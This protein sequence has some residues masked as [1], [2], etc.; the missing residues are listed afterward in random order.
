MNSHNPVQGAEAFGVYL[1]YQASTPLDR[2]VFEAMEPYLTGG[3]GNPHAVDHGYGWQADAAVSL[4]R[5]KIADLIG[6]DSDEIIF[7]SGA[8]E[9]NNLALLGAAR[10]SPRHRRRVLV[11]AIEHKCILAAARALDEEGF[12]VTILPV[13]SEGIIDVDSLREEIDGATAVVSVMS[14]NNEIGSLQPIATVAALSH[15]AGAL[16]HTDAAQALAVAG[17]DVNQSGADLM[18]LSAHKAYGPKGIGVL[19]VRREMRSRIRPVLFGG[20]QEDG[21]RPGT[22]PTSLCVGFGR[23]AEILQQERSNE[24]ARISALRDRLLET[25]RCRAPDLVLNGPAT[26]RHA[27]NLN[28]RFPGVAADLLLAAA[29]PRIAAAT[30][31]ACTSGTPEPS[32]VLTAMGIS[33]TAAGESIRLSIG[34]FTSKP[35]IDEAVDALA[36][37]LEEVRQGPEL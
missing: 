11:S 6:A 20:G 8:T 37:A 16:F 25:L 9:A 4:A 1:D 35:D 23:A 17:V 5:S 24:V 30:G 15:A 28:L 32:H 26:D 12:E 7:T 13:S 36:Q 3:I 27:G 31:S 22:L 21:L 10:A 19:Y 18:S 14:I 29:R 34:R 2:R 33:P